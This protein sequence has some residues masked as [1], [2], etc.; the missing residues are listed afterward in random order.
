MDEIVVRPRVTRIDKHESGTSHHYDR[1]KL[2]DSRADNLSEFIALT[3]GV[4]AIGSE[5]FVRGG[6]P[7]EVKTRVGDVS[8]SNLLAGRDGT[9]ANIAIQNID[10]HT[11]GF[12]AEYGG[13]C[14]GSST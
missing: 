7:D 5:L 11:G 12:D 1:Q 13:R 4:V 6:R 2:E 10:V 8:V 3:P 9:V 14:P